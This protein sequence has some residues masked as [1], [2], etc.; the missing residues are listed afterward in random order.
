MTPTADYR[1]W[2]S[3]DR[4]PELALAAERG[5]LAVERAS[6]RPRREGAL[7]RLRRRLGVLRAVAR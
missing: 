6:V 4:E 5:R 3:E 1:V 2:I 7:L